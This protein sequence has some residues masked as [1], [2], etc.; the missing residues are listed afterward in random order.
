MMEGAASRKRMIFDRDLL[1]RD[2]IS[3]GLPLP[4]AQLTLIASFETEVLKRDPGSLRLWNSNPGPR[5]EEK[6]TM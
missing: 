1:G 5:R 6:R 3:E 2:R 4:D